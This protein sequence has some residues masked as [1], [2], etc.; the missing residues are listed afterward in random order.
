MGPL[1]WLHQPTGPAFCPALLLYPEITCCW[2]RMVVAGLGL[3]L[4]S[5]CISFFF[6]SF[7]LA[8]YLTSLLPQVRYFIFTCVSHDSSTSQL[9][10]QAGLR[11]DLAEEVPEW[12]LVGSVH[13]SSLHPPHPKPSS[14]YF[15]EV[16]WTCHGVVALCMQGGTQVTWKKLSGTQPGV[17]E[18]SSSWP[19]G[20]KPPFILLDQV[21]FEFPETLEETHG[22]RRAPVLCQLRQV[23]MIKPREQS[24][25][26]L[27]DYF[28]GVFAKWK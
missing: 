16:S 11:D 18:L 20:I 13:L 2:S 24:Q 7:T 26:G 1:S 28:W 25:F 22:G 23:W 4:L 21:L 5:V 14:R 10:W 27:G 12:I 15:F 17:T 19:P 6:A 3:S 8:A 9:K